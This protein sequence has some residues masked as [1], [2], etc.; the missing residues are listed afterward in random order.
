MRKPT[1][2]PN[3]RALNLHH[4]INITD[5]FM[6]IIERCML[7]PNADDSF[8][9]KDP[10][11]GQI[12]EVVSAKELW[13]K[14]L[15]LRMQTGEPYIH[16]LSTS[17]KAMP[18]FQKKLGLSIK[19]SNLCLTGDTLIDVK[20]SS[21]CESVSTRLDEFVEKYSLGYYT[22][23]MVKS[24]LNGEVVWSKVSCAAQTAEVDEIYEIETPSGKVIRCTANHKIYT[25]NRGYVEAQHLLETDELMEI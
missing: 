18:E 8:E 22:D 14:I 4:G 11:D 16:F 20:Y 19:Q 12:R 2:D 24:V 13:M 9:L 15:E 21:S 10:H 3:M 25:I 1:G 7:D 5:D 6:Q 17:N 23:P